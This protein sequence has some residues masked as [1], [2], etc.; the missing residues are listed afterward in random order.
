MGHTEVPQADSESLARGEGTVF[1]SS[2]ASGI[3]TLT[4]ITLLLTISYWS[5]VSDL[6]DLKDEDDIFGDF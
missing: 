1:N 2:F 4:L 5:G 6:D 3:L